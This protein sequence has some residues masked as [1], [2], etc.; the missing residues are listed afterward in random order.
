[1]DSHFLDSK[2]A[3]AVLV[4]TSFTFSFTGSENYHLRK[5]SIERKA[6]IKT[7]NH[8]RCETLL[9]IKY[10]NKSSINKNYERSQEKCRI[11]KFTH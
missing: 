8:Q 4:H 9:F 5:K 3:A 10:T 7:V 1:M 6:L 2:G 11:R